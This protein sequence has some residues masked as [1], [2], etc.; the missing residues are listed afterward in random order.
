MRLRL[1]AV[2]ALLTASLFAHADNWDKD[3][4]VGNNPQLRVDTN[5][6]SIRITGGSGNRISAHVITRDY[7]IGP[8]YVRIDEKQVGDRVEILVKIPRHMGFFVGSRS[9]RIEINVPN[10]IQLEL[11]SGDGSLRVSDVSGP[12][13]LSTSDGSI[14][15]FG[16]EGSLVAHTADGS[17]RIDGRFDNLDV[18]TSDGSIDCSVR[19]GS[20]MTDRWSLRTSD[21][22]VRL[23]LPAEFAADL[24]AHTGDGHIRMSIPVTVEGMVGSNSV[25]GKINGGGQ[26][27]QIRT[28][29]GSINIDRV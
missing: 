18:G 10:K 3:Y 24:D 27:L 9:V 6:A 29:D 28:S 13:K 5:D 16:Y 22:S 23:R 26:P 2:A 12:A 15:M 8:N 21:G 17:V 19:P 4:N 25:R 20:K 11:R 14:E 1:L 7:K